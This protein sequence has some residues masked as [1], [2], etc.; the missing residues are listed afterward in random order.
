MLKNIFI[1]SNVVV[2]VSAVDLPGNNIEEWY[3]TNDNEARFTQVR[4]V[5]VAG[6]NYSALPATAIKFTRTMGTNDGIM[7]E[8]FESSDELRIPVSKTRSCFLGEWC[9]G[10]KQ[11]RDGVLVFDLRNVDRNGVRTSWISKTGNH[12]IQNRRTKNDPREDP[13]TFAHLDLD[14]MLGL[15]EASEPFSVTLKQNDGSASRNDFYYFNKNGKL[16]DNIQCSFDNDTQR[17]ELAKNV[18]HHLT[19]WIGSRAATNGSPVARSTV[20]STTGVTAAAA[21]SPTSTTGV[22]VDG[23][24]SPTSTTFVTAAYVAASGSP[25]ARPSLETPPLRA[26]PRA[27][28]ARRQGSLSP[29]GSEA[30]T[31]SDDGSSGASVQPESEESEHQESEESE[32]V[33][34]PALKFELQNNIQPGGIDGLVNGSQGGK[35]PDFDSECI[36]KVTT[37]FEREVATNDKIKMEMG[38]HYE[39]CGEGEYHMDSQ[40]QI[41]VVQE[42]IIV[43]LLKKVVDSEFQTETQKQEWIERVATDLV[44]EE[45]EAIKEFIVDCRDH[46]RASVDRK[47]QAENAALNNFRKRAIATA[48]KELDS[49]I[50]GENAISFG[51]ELMRIGIT[52]S[53]L[54]DT[55]ADDVFRKVFKHL[56]KENS[57]LTPQAHK[58]MQREA[59]LHEFRVVDSAA[60]FRSSPSKG[61]YFRHI[62]YMFSR[63][64][65]Q[66]SN[67]YKKYDAAL[68]KAEDQIL[69]NKEIEKR[70]FN[71]YIETATRA[72]FKQ[73]KTNIKANDSTIGLALYKRHLGSEADM[74]MAAKKELYKIIISYFRSI[75]FTGTIAYLE[76]KPY[77]WWKVNAEGRRTSADEGSHRVFAEKIISNLLETKGTEILKLIKDAYVTKGT[78][79]AEEFA[80][81]YVTKSIIEDDDILGQIKHQL[82]YPTGNK[83]GAFQSVVSE[84]LVKALNEDGPL[85]DHRFKCPHFKKEILDNLYGVRGATRDLSH[86][87]LLNIAMRMLQKHL[88]Q[89]EIN[90]LMSHIEEKFG[91]EPRRSVR[92]AVK[93][94]NP[95]AHVNFG[96]LLKEQPTISL[97]QRPE[98]GSLA[99]VADGL[100]DTHT[101]FDYDSPVTCDGPKKGFFFA[102]AL[103]ANPQQAET[104]AAQVQSGTFAAQPLQRTGNFRGAPAAARRVSTPVAETS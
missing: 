49:D 12:I 44:H 22:A 47:E 91:A 98:A 37:I 85:C 92:G 4:D 25:P 68:E 28:A 9:A 67:M 82:D 1:A 94:R 64:L 2:A 10:L 33:Y 8:M 58:A 43:E 62:A 18:I 90:R 19:R 84:Q 81:Q 45:K 103:D 59:Q 53:N 39:D 16:T 52:R 99:S 83:K 86:S 73:L 101:N 55:F 87:N 61:E 95:T 14:G 89:A 60:E 80:V 66:R 26:S 21:A 42:Y 76:S 74:R 41:N 51:T 38:K 7:N 93:P 3:P 20:A 50:G 5:K 36:A 75:Q 97:Q 24:A 48:M 29:S 30:C 57:A 54:R 56:T 27:T 23:A 96:E 32:Q 11:N 40:N 65:S 79:G 17:L 78:D 63:T 104:L 6:T 34:L 77:T 69:R 35:N 88:N 13:L 31:D 15:Q 46:Y 71:E 72:V 100:Y 102:D 70:L